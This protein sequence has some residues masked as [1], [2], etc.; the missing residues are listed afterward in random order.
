[1]F[2]ILLN[3]NNAKLIAKSIFNE[4]E[5]I[6]ETNFNIHLDIVAAFFPKFNNDILYQDFNI[7][8]Y[9]NTDIKLNGLRK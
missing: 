2:K 3:K 8:P 9:S 7:F 1:M 4:Y 6:A 5:I